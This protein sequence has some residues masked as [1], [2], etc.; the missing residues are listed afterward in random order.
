MWC[1]V[2]SLQSKPP[3]FTEKDVSDP[4]TYKFEWETAAACKIVNVVGEKCAVK[5]PKSDTTFNLL[6]LTKRRNKAVYSG[7]L[8]DNEGQGKFELNICGEVP[9]CRKGVEKTGAC[10]TTGDGRKI[11]LGKFNTKLEYMGEILTLV[12]RWVCQIIFSWSL[13]FWLKRHCR[14]FFWCYFKNRYL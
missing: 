2:F 9:D 14:I 10:L 13:Y 12:Y 3:K 5:D 11:V 6:P 8:T 4:C 1:F 7:N